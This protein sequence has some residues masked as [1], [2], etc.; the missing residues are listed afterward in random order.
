MGVDRLGGYMNTLMRRT[1]LG[2]AL[3]LLV[4]APAVLVAGPAFAAATSTT[5]ALSDATPVYGQEVRATAS[6]TSGGQPVTEG[7]VRFTLS[8]PGGSVELGPVP[9]GS[10][11]VAASPVLTDPDGGALD[12]TSGGD[13]Y[14]VRADYVAS[15]AHAG[16]SGS[17]DDVVV[18]QAD[19]TTG[20]LPGATTITADVVGSFPGGVQEGSLRPSGSVRFAVNGAPAGSAQLDADG[21]ATIDYPLPNGAPQSIT[22]TYAGD[23]DD[24]YNGSAHTAVRDDPTITARVVSSAPRAKSGWY[25]STV[26][27]WFKCDPARSELVVECPDVVRLR[28]N[29]SNQSVTR[30]IVAADGGRATITVS[31]IDIDR[32]KPSLNIVDR[33]TCKASDNLSGVRHG[34]CSMRA[35]GGDRYLAVAVDRAG[36]RAWKRIYFG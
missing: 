26:Q 7:S 19:T 16:S 6:V 36:N 18:G 23:T 17:V 21:R 27:I 9:V 13:S 33:R 12:A 14:D 29:G 10:G 11:G 2:L 22:A 35:L 15:G 1:A 8:G 32:N 24:N 31:G 5:V 30:T 4:G 3:P 25:G 34:R 20:I 28:G